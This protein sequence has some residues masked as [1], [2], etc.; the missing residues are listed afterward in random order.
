MRHRLYDHAA[1]T[2]IKFTLVESA[3]LETKADGTLPPS[4][5]IVGPT[6]EFKNFFKTHFDEIRYLDLLFD[7][8]TVTK[9]AWVLPIAAQTEETGTLADFLLELGA[10]V[11]EVP[12][13]DSDDD[14][15]DEEEDEDGFGLT[16]EDL[17][18]G[19]EDEA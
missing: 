19:D 9:S 16:A 2:K 11:E 8:G 15:E 13:A 3:D 18:L 17:D 6:Y 12:M 4:I 7:G 14:V 1:V 10:E 5:F